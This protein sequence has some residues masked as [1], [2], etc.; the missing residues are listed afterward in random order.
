VLVATDSP[1][2]AAY[3]GGTQ[4]CTVSANGKAW[5]WG[6]NWSAQLGIGVVDLLPH[7]S[8]TAV[9]G[10]LQFQYLVIGDRHACGIAD[11]DA[12]YCWGGGLSGQ[13]GSGSQS[14]T[15]PALPEPCNRT[16]QRVTA[17]TTFVTLA[18]GDEHTCGLDQDGHA[19]CWGG[20]RYGQI[21]DGT[22]TNRSTPVP[23]VGGL[24]FQAIAAAA[25]HTCALDAQ[26]AAWC[27]G[28]NELSQL[29]AGTELL[30]PYPIAVAGGVVFETLTAGGSHTCGL[31][32]DG[33]AYCWGFNGAG[34]LGVGST[35]PAT[36]PTAVATQ[37][38]FASLTAGWTHTCGLAT[39]GTAHCWGRNNTGQ[40]G[41]GVTGGIR[42]T[43]TCLIGQPG[44]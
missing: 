4:V 1:F 40:L 35:D 26:G 9:A 15:C 7:P 43:P 27:W 41:I 19:Y 18:A 34:E 20:N 12:T 11:D 10:E 2:T 5:C 38:R 28:D 32:A 13:L 8:P 25:W 29:G 33:V 14:F 6:A 44:G 23:V 31:D 24:T 30:Y 39:D 3:A 42:T 16:P 36:Q 17:A 22:T 21:G 37:L